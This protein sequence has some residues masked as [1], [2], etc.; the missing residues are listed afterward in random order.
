MKNAISARELHEFLKVETRYDKWINRMIDYCFVENQDFITVAQKR[1]TA[2]GNITTFQD[3]RYVS[4]N[5]K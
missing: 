4:K 2:Q 5:F 1:P 3:P